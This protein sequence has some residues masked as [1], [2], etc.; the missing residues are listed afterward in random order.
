M[1]NIPCL[2]SFLYIRDMDVYI[3]VCLLIIDLGALGF[4]RMVG[5]SHDKKLHSDK[6]VSL[7]LRKT[8][9]LRKMSGGQ[10]YPSW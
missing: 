8:K 9:A 3:A 5:Q 4:P 10:G 6:I 1:R 2:A 7:R